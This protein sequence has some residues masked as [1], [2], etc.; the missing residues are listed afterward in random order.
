[1]NLNLGTTLSQ[2]PEKFHQAFTLHQRGQL[3][4]ARTLYEEILQVDPGHFEALHLLGV[5]AF[6]TRDLRKAVDFFTKAIEVDSLNAVAFYNR[7]LALKQLEQFEAAL[8][9][10]DSAIALKPD[11]TEAYFNR[12]NLLREQQQFEAALASYENAIAN[13]ADHAEAYLNRGNVLRELQQF[14]AAL[15]S[16]DRA[17]AARRDYAE[18]HANRGHALRDLKQHEAAIACYDR[19]L[20]LKPDFRFLLGQRRHSKMQICDWDNLD[21]DML[22]LS[23][24]IARQEA[25]CNPFS[26]LGLSGSPELQKMCAE[27]WMREECRS[28]VALPEKPPRANHDKI[29]LGY[30]SAD[31]RNH[32]VSILTAELFE[33]HDRSRFEVIAF[34]S[35]PDTQDAMRTR[36]QGAF[37]RFYD[38]RSR[39]DRDIALLARDVE[40][41]IAVDLGGFTTGSRWRVLA[42]RAAP[43]QVSY[44][45]YLG[46]MAANYMDYL[47]ADDII[48]PADCQKHY[49]EKLVYLPSYQVNDSKRCISDRRFLRDELGLPDSGFVFCCFND[50][51]KI[52]PS[53]FD[54]W[55]RILNKVQ[56]G[57]LLLY[58]ANEAAKRNLR[59]EAVER[60]VGPNRIVFGSKLPYA[61][62]LAR[63]RSADLFLDTWPYNAGTTASDALW[64]G[65]PVVTCVGEAFAGRVAA[66]LLHAVGLPELIAPT[67]AEYEQL[68]IDLAADPGRLA[69]V[70]SRLADSRPRTA[71]FDTR[72]F[73]KHLEAAYTQM[74]ARHRAGLP[75]EHIRIEAIESRQPSCGKLTP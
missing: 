70:K 19:A 34:S 9:S 3:A 51:Y 69:A 55:M 5:I 29:R 75:P 1:V 48:V 61:D 23:F 59:K 49:S 62:Y 14:D 73:T 46:T 31:Y 47:I 11:Y 27:I 39:S 26:L 37:D 52:T 41:D 8:A 40:L 16:Y 7:G 58:A 72:G 57:V 67:P 22:E 45:G 2:L 17:L 63:Y 56:D 33:I 68:A 24:R 42:M 36:M 30:F 32:A 6:Q 21:A 54:S 12:G 43:L 18:G 10:Y 71:L 38:V 50:N 13:K 65:L 66:S 25:V 64:V 28:K 20:A 44:L 60:G 35:G 74:Y 15:A 4:S 53:A